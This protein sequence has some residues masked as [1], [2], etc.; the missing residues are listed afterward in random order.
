MT[1]TMVQSKTEK[2]KTNQIMTI[3]TCQTERRMLDTSVISVAD[4]LPL[5]EEKSS[6]GKAVS[7]SSGAGFRS[8]ENREMMT[9]T[10]HMQKI[11]RL[12]LTSRK[13]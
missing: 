5:L 7:L 1:R 3:T 4:S 11:E 2:N 12:G 10:E 9:M 8:S 13:K 6:L